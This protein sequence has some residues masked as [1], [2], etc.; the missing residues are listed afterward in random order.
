MMEPPS[1][2][3][4]SLCSPSAS[5][6]PHS[7]RGFGGTEPDS[8]RGPAGDR[9]PARP[10]V[11]SGLRSRAPRAPPR[12]SSRRR[13]RSAGRGEEPPAAPR[14]LGAQIRGRRDSGDAPLSGKGQTP[15]ER[16]RE[17]GTD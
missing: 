17:P 14:R 5:A 7:L 15:P 2:I 10:H 9:L 11:S 1:T 6:P 3:Q 12:R 13:A 4:G 16:M 8:S